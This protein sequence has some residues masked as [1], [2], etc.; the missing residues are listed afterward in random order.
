MNRP[1]GHS[2][3]VI[4]HSSFVMPLAAFP[5][6]FLDALCV[7][8]TM[9]VDDWLDMA[10]RLD[11]DGY[12]FYWGFTPW[13]QPD[14]LER[15]RRRVEDQGRSIPMMCYSPDFTK[16]DKEERQH[17][18]GQQIEAV[19]AT[20]HLG[21]SYCRVLSGQRRPEVS[22]EQGIRWVRE[23]IHEV[24]PT[25]ESYGITLILENHYK[26]GYWMHPEF[27]QKMDVFLELLD[28]IGTHS[29]FGINYD[30]SNAIVAGDDPIELLEAV[31]DRVVTMHASDRYLEG[32]T[33]E[34]LRK[35]EA[36]PQAGYAHILKH[37][38]IGQGMN[39]YD[40][41]FSI[42]KGAGFNGWISIEDGQDPENG[43]EHLE[44]SARFLRGK[45]VQHELT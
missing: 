12:E 24:L 18:V 31:K 36:H 7:H 17:E 20:A 3:F 37:G 16:P 15:L 27:A 11:V 40:R 9:T 26:D 2:S 6:C 13:Q 32:G 21:G 4:R 28:A 33:L 25:A 30:P 45:M 22:R 44:E 42:L 41:I 5:K 39:D 14:E 29:H 1:Y 35:I 10:G 34:D 38:V 43:F 19:K 8:H 23:C